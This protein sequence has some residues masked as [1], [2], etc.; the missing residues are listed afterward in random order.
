LRSVKDVA[1]KDSGNYFASDNM[2]W[3]KI[4]LYIVWF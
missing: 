3:S 2:N 1:Q 4:I